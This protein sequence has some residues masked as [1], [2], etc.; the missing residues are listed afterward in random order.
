MKKYTYRYTGPIYHNGN[1]I[2]S[3]S[4]MTTTAVSIKKA[5]QNFLY[6]IANGDYTNH[7]DI[8]PQ[9]IKK[10]QPSNNS[11][12]IAEIPKCEVCGHHL[13]TIGECPICDIGE[14]D[15]EA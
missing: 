2:A 8:I 15:M 9:Y 5:E 1:K 6:R 14:T 3:K 13:T 11:I 10:L 7:Y 12:E 4:N